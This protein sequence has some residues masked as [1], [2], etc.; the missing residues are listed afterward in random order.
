[1]ESSTPPRDT[2]RAMSEEN[3]EIVRRGFDAV[4]RGDLERWFGDVSAEITV[5]PRA[6]EPGVKNCYEG[7][8]GI[9]EYLANWYS[10]WESYTVEPERFID[11]GD[12]VVVDVREVGVA[13]QSGMRV[14]ENFAHAF[15][16][17]D[18]K[19]VEWRMFGPMREALEAAGL[20][21]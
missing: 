20:S 7:H 19:V 16:V 4:A 15:K 3:V 2:A 12:Y 9:L 1:M 8:E 21:E 11:G 17:S 18:G 10:G 14:E 6:E 13:Q 5:Y